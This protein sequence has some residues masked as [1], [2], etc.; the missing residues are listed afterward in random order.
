MRRLWRQGECVEVIGSVP[1]AYSP[2]HIHLRFP[3]PRQV[4]SSAVLGGGLTTADH[5]LNKKVSAQASSET[6]DLSPQESPMSTPQQSLQAYATEQGWEGE[7]IGMMTAASMNSLRVVECHE[8]GVDLAV[9]VTAGIENARRAGDKAEHRLMGEEATECGTINLVAITSARLTPAALTEAV[10]TMTEAKAAVM[11][12]HAISSPVSGDM[13]TGTGTDAI[14]VVNGTGPVEVAYCGKHV[15][16][17]ELLAR[18]TMEA[19]TAS[20][21]YYFPAGKKIRSSL[22]VSVDKTL[23]SH[24]A[25]DA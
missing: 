3:T 13:A 4:L 23:E 21:A 22:E 17:G 1:L 10:I 5:L 8:Q 24:G 2:D 16:F 7:T 25:A 9:L 14:A 12:E 20:L 6:C 18:C 11:Q 15:I 19:I